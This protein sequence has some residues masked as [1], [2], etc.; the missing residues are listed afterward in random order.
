MFQLL[1]IKYFIVMLVLLTVSLLTATLSFAHVSVKPNQ[2]GVAAYQTFNVSVP[3]EKDNPTTGIRLVIPAGLEH[4]SPNVKPGWSVEIK[5]AGESMKGEVLNTGEKAP[6]PETVTEIIWTGGS[7][8][9]GMRDDF[10]FSAKTPADPGELQWKAYQT[11]ADGVTVAWD[12]AKDAQPKDASGADDFSVSGPYSTTKIVNDLAA[13]PKASSV[14]GQVLVNS[15]TESNLP[16]I[17][18][19]LAVIISGF[20]LG[21]TLRK[22]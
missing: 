20:A 14:P 1:S 13:S 8:P 15:E 3:N 5:R 2:V 10:Y 16:L 4:T 22:R 18:S 9:A 19:A 17:L 7:I 21:L 11:Y 12:L 6:D